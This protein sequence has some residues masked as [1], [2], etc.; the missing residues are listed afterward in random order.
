MGY[1]VSEKILVQVKPSWAWSMGNEDRQKRWPGEGGVQY[2]GP[3]D[4]WNN[5]TAFYLAAHLRAFDE[6][7]W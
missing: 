7:D 6:T 3:R 5:S 1:L 2:Q 4:M